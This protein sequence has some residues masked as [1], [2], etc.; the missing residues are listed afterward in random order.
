MKSQLIERHLASQT[1]GEVAFLDVVEHVTGDGSE[2]VFFG[3]TRIEPDLIIGPAGSEFIGMCTVAGT[4]M[5]RYRLPSKTQKAFVMG[6]VEH[7][8]SA[9][10]S[11]LDLLAGTNAMVSVRNGESAASVLEW[12][13]YHIAHHGMNAAVILD[14]SKPKTD[15]NFFRNLR[16]GLMEYELDCTVVIVTSDIPLGQPN[17]PPEAHPYCVESAPSKDRLKVPAPSPWDAPFAAMLWYEIA[18]ARFLGSARAVAN[19]DVHDLALPGETNIFDAALA[20]ESGVVTLVGT[21]TYPWRVRNGDTAHFGDH[22]CVQFDATRGRLRWC[23][24]PQKAPVEVIWRMVRVANSSPNPAQNRQFYR[25]MALRHPTDQISKIVPK[26]ALIEHPSLLKQSREYFGHKPVRMPALGFTPSTGSRDRRVIVTAM[27]NEGAFILEWVAFHKAI[28]FD[29]IIV[30]SNDCTDGTETMLELLDRKGILLHRQNPYREMNLRPQHAAL[31]SA[32]EEPVIKNAK[33]VVCIDVDEYVNI[34][35]GDGTLDALFNAV[36]DANLISM[37]WRLFGNSDIHA[38]SDLPITQQFTRCAPE[39]ARK[40][41]QAW[42]F[43]TLFKNNGIFG[44]LGVHRPKSLR[45]QLWESINWVNGSGI[46]LPREIY[47]NGWRSTANTYGYDLVQLNHYA[48]RSTESF[49]VKRDRGRVN[50]VN[51]DQGLSYWFRM[52]NNSVEE[53]SIQKRLDLMQ[54]EHR[55]LMADPEIAAAHS[56]CVAHH[57]KKIQNLRDTDN[58]AEFYAALTRPKMSRLAR[59]HTHFGANVFLSGPDAVPDQIAEQNP[60]GDWFFTVKKPDETDH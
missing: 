14:R 54:S 16:A 45:T 10:E 4:T 30:Y 24:A 26:S 25:H 20:A 52:N 35:V 21:Q 43:K 37:T 2:L 36:P 46:Q 29:D 47:R 18:R 8:F 56:D 3:Q 32:E 22:V 55:K 5:L 57:R 38:F 49:L 12:I 11:E 34:K 53:L 60:D 51:R 23:I 39:Y 28:G 27:K 13:S 7:C 50:H 6:D 33:W 15:P 19:L 42:G 17:M 44:K 1:V 40:P 48:V 9:A 58:Y 59:L 41:H 31:Q